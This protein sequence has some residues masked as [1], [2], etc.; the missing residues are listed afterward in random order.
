M[1]SKKKNQI[2]FYFR[3]AGGVE[4]DEGSGSDVSEINENGERV[5]R[6]RPLR[7]RV[8]RREEIEREIEVERRKLQD[9]TEKSKKERDKIARALIDKQE[10]LRLM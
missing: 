3:T 6:K 2:Q 7:V 8:E 9:D 1:K 5:V 10:E 4:D